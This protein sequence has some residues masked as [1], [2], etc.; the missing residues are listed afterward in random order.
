MNKIRITNLHQTVKS[1]IFTI[2][3]NFNVLH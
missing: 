3:Y 1:K 2:L